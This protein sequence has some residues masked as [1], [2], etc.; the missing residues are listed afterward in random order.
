[1]DRMYGG[2]P[3]RLNIV[4]KKL[5]NAYINPYQLDISFVDKDTL[6]FLGSY[7]KLFSRRKT[8]HDNLV[9]LNKNLTIFWGDLP[10]G[11]K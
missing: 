4:Q 7:K 10:D 2:Y 9:E 5:L 6:R 11:K 8:I 1:M 3:P